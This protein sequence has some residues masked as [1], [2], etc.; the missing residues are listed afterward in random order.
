[1][2]ALVMQEIPADREGYRKVQIEPW[3]SPGNQTGIRMQINDH[4]QLA[5]PKDEQG[6]ARIIKILRENF[7]NS[8]KKSKTIVSQLMDFAGG[9]K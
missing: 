5:D 9:L 4:Y 1:M 7:E 6:A 2:L 3:N 8:I